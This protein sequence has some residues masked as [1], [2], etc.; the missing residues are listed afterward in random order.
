MGKYIKALEYGK[1]ALEIQSKVL[2]NSHET[3]AT[4]IE[5]LSK[6]YWRMGD[7]EKSMS[8]LKEVQEIRENILP[9]THID[10]VHSFHNYAVIANNNFIDIEGGLFYEKKAIKVIQ[11][12]SPIDSARLAKAYKQLFSIYK[13]LNKLEDG[14]KQLDRAFEIN[15]KVNMGNRL[16]PSMLYYFNDYTYY[17]FVKEEY[18]IASVMLDT[19]F[20]ILQRLAPDKVSLLNNNRAMLLARTGKCDESMN[21]VNGAFDMLK[22]SDLPETHQSYY[23]VY[24]TIAEVN[25]CNGDFVKAIENSNKLITYYDT[26]IEKSFSTK[27]RFAETLYFS[28][29]IHCE[30]G[31][32]KKALALNERAIQL[33]ENGFPDGYHLIDKIKAH[34]SQVEKLQG[35]SNIK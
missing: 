17:Y 26:L 14:K 16:A 8:L 4:S 22:K 32:R 13:N 27:I 35:C 23:D 29:L 33:I 6:I 30:I 34:I 9:E 25:K 10:L 21:L 19:A 5:N 24:L 2:P 18:E 20:L 31:E 1:E 7:M 12:Q 28:A 15:L 3:I 11:A